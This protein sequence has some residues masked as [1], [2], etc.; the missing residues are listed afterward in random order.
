MKLRV[1]RVGRSGLVSGCSSKM[2]G[3]AGAGRTC[4]LYVL[5]RTTRRSHMMLE[6]PARLQVV[7]L[8][9]GW[10]VEGDRGLVTLTVIQARRLLAILLFAT[11]RMRL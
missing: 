2:A 10:R 1:A 11:N 5:P 4:A 3:A 9:G 7:E 8:G 6:E